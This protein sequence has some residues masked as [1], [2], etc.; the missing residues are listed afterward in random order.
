MNRWPVHPRNAR[1]IRHTSRLQQGRAF[2]GVGHGERQSLAGRTCPVDHRAGAAV[3]PR[4]LR[5]MLSMASRLEVIIVT[6]TRLSLRSTFAVLSC[7]LGA[8]WLTPTAVTHAEVMDESFPAVTSVGSR[9]ACVS[10]IPDF[11][12]AA[13]SG[14]VASQGMIGVR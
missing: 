8:D 7:R 14:E 2:G 9:R 3:W 13:V 6:I 12:W 4:D 11:P 5:V 1:L 10:R